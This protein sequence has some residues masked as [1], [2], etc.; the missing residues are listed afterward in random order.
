M[1][2]LGL[3]LPMIEFGRAMMGSEVACNAARAG[4]RAGVIPGAS[5]ATITS[6]VNALLSSEMV[7]G[8]TT[9]IRVNGSVNDVSTALQ[10][11][12]ISVTVNIPYNSISWLPA[13]TSVYLAGKTITSTEVMRHE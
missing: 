5:N 2:F 11:D 13:G 4:C 9:T 10:G 3:A 12:T 8:A 7:S 6:A 1:L